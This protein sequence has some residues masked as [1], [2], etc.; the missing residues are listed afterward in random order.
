[1]HKFNFRRLLFW[2]VLTAFIWVVISR[3]TQIESLVK[4]LLEG[5][6]QWVTAAALLQFGYFTL[7]AASYQAAFRT[8][9]IKSRTRQLLPL[10]FAAIFVNVVTPTG[11]AAGAALYVDDAAQRGESPLRATAAMMLQLAI[12]YAV[13]ALVLLVGMI[14]LFS[15]HNLQTYQ[16]LGALV[17]L[18]VTLVLGG[19]LA[20]GLWYPGRVERWLAWV[21]RLAARLAAWFKRSPFLPED[22]A[23]KMAGD[24]TGAAA[25][26]AQN[27][28]QLWR[29]AFFLLVS[30]LINLAS[31]Y[32]VFMAFH[33]PID[34]G[35]LVAGYAIG[36]L[37]WIVS[38]TPQGIGV[39]EGVMAL[40]FTSFNVPGSAATIIVLAFRGLGFWLPL[41]VGFVVLRRVRTFNMGARTLSE[42][43]VGRFLSIMVGLMGVV[44]VISAVTPSLPDRLA[45]LAEFSPLGVQHGGNLTAALSGFA[46]LMLA[47]N[48]W[49]RKH[50]AWMMTLG[51]LILSVFSHLIKGLD[52]EE[53]TLAAGL[54]LLLWAQR[55]HFHAASDRPAM[56]QAFRVLGGAVF[57]TLAYGVTGFFFLDRHYSV[58]FGFYEALRQTVIMF[59]EFYNPGLE[60]ITGFGKYFADSIYGVGM[61]TF[62]YAL[63]M[64]LRPVFMHPSADHGE[65]ARARNIIEAYGRTALAR[66]ALFDDKSFYFS[67]GGSVIAYAARDRAGFALGDPIGPPEDVPAALEGFKTFCARN[68]WTPA[69]YQTLPDYLPHYKDAGF[70]AVCIGQEAIVD[71]AAFTLEGKAA[72]DMRTSIN[73]MGREGYRFELH[74]APLPA[75]F[76]AELRTISDEW[77]TT[78]HGAEKRFSLGWF[79]EAYL[80]TCPVAA[81]HAPDGM[82]AAFA[83]IVPEFRKNEASLDLMRRRE[84]IPNGT[85]EFLFA[86]IFQWAKAQGYATFNLGLSALSGVGERPDDPV[87]E[88]MLHFIYEHINQFYN[89]QGLHKFK[90]KFTPAWEPR[91]LIY[92]GAAALPG[93]LT[94]LVKVHSSENF[95]WEYLKKPG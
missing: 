50:L 18:A 12:D 13:F 2:F 37:F 14:F 67:P 51:A 7:L 20:M 27:P 92:P 94:A 95:M 52:Y 46:L 3:F 90:E 28:H 40:V 59:T 17:L 86:S 93:L 62:S 69:F 8:V 48:L 35:P 80:Q 65:Q 87:P 9:G 47:R 34:L 55:Y 68:D 1:M 70:E 58:N 64:L 75:E 82:V 33:Q 61:V 16:V 26:V 42:V 73:R 31:L 54:A 79:D 38:P 66:Y 32:A 76:L 43:W 41:L 60:P 36:I 78:M 89:F 81:V 19:T 53:A 15:T 22:W 83:N 84:T 21:Q 24:F 4:T 39:V 74:P 71:L 5:Q 88:R 63:L 56:R 85:M 72:K 29:T 10:T 30:H 57:F 77:L 6:W 23:A 91:Y 45:I 25:A 49:R 44:N 11:S